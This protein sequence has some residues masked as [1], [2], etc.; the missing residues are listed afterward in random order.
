MQQT[1]LTR[2]KYNRHARFYNLTEIPM[3]L[4]LFRR[5]R[6]RLLE[7]LDGQRILEIG[8][9]TGKNLKYYPENA[10]VVGIDLSE[11]MMAKA[12]PIAQSKGIALAQMDAERLAFPDATFEAVVATFVF[13][14]V[15]DPVAGFKEIKRV[16]KPGG[17][18]ILL[19]HV[20]P[21]NR[22]LAWLFNRLNNFTVK[23]SGVHINRKTAA[24]IRKA[25]LQ[26][27]YEKNLFGTIFKRFNTK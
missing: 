2:Q 3:E 14:S 18:V 23:Q 10:T 13:C 5:W 9:G 21:E 15:P 1:E 27:L 26:I 20:L 12:I 25:G 24:N 4:V 22:L 19:E 16:L 6:R 8:V 17:Q 7:N 11:G